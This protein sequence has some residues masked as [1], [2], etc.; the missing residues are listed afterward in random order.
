MRRKLV[1]AVVVVLMIA[2]AIVVI[3][4][5]RY[6]MRIDSCLDAGGVWSYADD[7]CETGSGG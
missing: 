6:H 4:F 1:I 2:V 3:P 5:L 7:R